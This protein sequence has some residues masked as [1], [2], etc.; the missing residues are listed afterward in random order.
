MRH[1]SSVVRMDN[2][3]FHGINDVTYLSDGGRGVKTSLFVA[4]VSGLRQQ[5]VRL[6]DKEGESGNDVNHVYI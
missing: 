6:F 5:L 1:L 4:M 2:V 3:L